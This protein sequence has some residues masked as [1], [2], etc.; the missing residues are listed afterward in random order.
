MGNNSFQPVGKLAN[1]FTAA[2]ENVLEAGAGLAAVVLGA[3]LHTQGPEVQ[4]PHVLRSSRAGLPGGRCRY[5]A[6]ARLRK[7]FAALEN[8]G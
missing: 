5:S 2:C 8:C 3:N 6:P 4:L 1:Q 7:Y